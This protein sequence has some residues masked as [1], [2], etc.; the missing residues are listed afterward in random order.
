MNHSCTKNGAAPGL[1]VPRRLLNLERP[2]VMN[3][4]GTANHPQQGGRP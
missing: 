3:S 1:G 4:K 2:S